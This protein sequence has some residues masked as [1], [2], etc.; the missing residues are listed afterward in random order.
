MLAFVI[1]GTTGRNGRPLNAGTVVDLD[2]DT[3]ARLWM[4]RDI[5]AP[6]PSELTPTT[7]TKRSTR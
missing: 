4:H 6:K 1:R 2:P 5:R 3:H 7:N